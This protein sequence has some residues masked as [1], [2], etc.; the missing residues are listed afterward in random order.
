MTEA[1]GSVYEMKNSGKQSSKKQLHTNMIHFGAQ[2][3]VK[4]LSEGEIVHTTVI[5]GV[6]VQYETKNGNL[7]V[8]TVNFDEASIK[9]WRFSTR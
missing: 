9:I 6:R 4:T 8:M 1:V 7:Y 2:L 5:Y 3:T